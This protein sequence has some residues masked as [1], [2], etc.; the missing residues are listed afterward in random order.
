M[1]CRGFIPSFMSSSPHVAG[2]VKS[3]GLLV[4]KARKPRTLNTFDPTDE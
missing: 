4:L 1:E 3:A 2:K